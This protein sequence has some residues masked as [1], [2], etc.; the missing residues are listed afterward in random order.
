LLDHRPRGKRSKK[1]NGKYDRK[2]GKRKDRNKRE[3]KRENTFVKK[4]GKSNLLVNYPLSSG[5]SRIFSRN[6]SMVG[7]R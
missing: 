3:S 7:F 4:Y 5:R 1:A 2:K 6:I